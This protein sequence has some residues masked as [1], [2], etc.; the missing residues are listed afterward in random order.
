MRLY[1]LALRWACGPF[2]RIYLFPQGN[3]S[4]EYHVVGMPFD[5]S[6]RA[7]ALHLTGQ[8]GFLWGVRNVA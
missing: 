3:T 2:F 1:P 8:N 6:K 7:E 5:F 4:D